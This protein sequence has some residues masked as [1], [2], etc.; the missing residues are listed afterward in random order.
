[1]KSRKGVTSIIATALLVGITVATAATLTTVV[2]NTGKDIKSTESVDLS[3]EDLNVEQCYTNGVE[4]NLSIRN[5]GD[6]AANLSRLGVLVNSSEKDYSFSQ[7]I[8]NPSETFTLTIQDELQPRER[9]T[10]V[11]GEDQL[12]YR[13]LEVS[14]TTVPAGNS[15]GTTTGELLERGGETIPALTF[16]S[17]SGSKSII[18]Y[19]KL[20]LGDNC[21]FEQGSAT[22][23]DTDDNA[24]DRSGDAVSGAIRTSKIN[25]TND[26]CIGDSC[27][28]TTGT[29]SGHLTESG[30]MDGPLL[31]RNITS[32]SSLCLGENC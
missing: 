14:E 10:V 22:T 20:C 24:I 29:T 4:T 27:P 17:T 18:G 16:G 23:F 13:C 25:Y 30:R 6:E 3:Q 11:S 28:A 26:I 31:I 12:T 15:D 32:S 8:A 21:G 7:V 19:N 9:V 1:M 5:T 2:Q